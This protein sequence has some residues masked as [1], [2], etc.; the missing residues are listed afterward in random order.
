MTRLN[1]FKSRVVDVLKKRGVLMNVTAIKRAVG[2][3]I[4][5][6]QTEAIQELAKAGVIESHPAL[7][8]AL[9]GLPRRGV[10]ERIVMNYEA[11]LRRMDSNTASIAKHVSN[12]EAENKALHS[13]ISRYRDIIAGVS[14]PVNINEL[15]PVGPNTV[16]GYKI[17]QK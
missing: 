13:E 12:L 11:Q 14:S 17:E 7:H 1:L 6:G 8:G 4:F 16:G 2:G 15:N 5:P 3:G 10:Y 9:Y